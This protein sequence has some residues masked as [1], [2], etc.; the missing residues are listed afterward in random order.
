V[1]LPDWGA[2]A[3]AIRTSVLV[4]AR[5]QGKNLLAAFRAIARP[6]PLQAIPAH[7]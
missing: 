1:Q 7:A 2:E 5:K 4:T 3:S 6:S